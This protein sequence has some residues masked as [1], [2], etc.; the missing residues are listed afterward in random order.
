MPRN[1]DW[2]SEKL[3]GKHR[4]AGKF[5]VKAFTAMLKSNDVP[6]DGEWAEIPDKQEDGWQGRYAMTGRIQLRHRLAETG[7]LRL[8]NETFQV[9]ETDRTKWR[10]NL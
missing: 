4:T 2:L 6:M 10:R 9:P 5:D 7:K 8:G 1:N 3:K